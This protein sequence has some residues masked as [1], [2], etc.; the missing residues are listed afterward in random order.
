[1]RVWPFRE[2]SEYR[3]AWEAAARNVDLTKDNTTVD[4]RLAEAEKRTPFY[5][6]VW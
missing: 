2:S 6:R 5:R 4:K 1:M 3:A